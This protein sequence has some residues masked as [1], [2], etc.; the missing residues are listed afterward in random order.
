MEDSALLADLAAAFERRLAPVQ[1]CRAHLDSPCDLS[2]RG[3][4]PGGSL[5]PFFPVPS[6]SENPVALAFLT[7]TQ[8]TM[9]PTATGQPPLPR[10]AEMA[11]EGTPGATW[12]RSSPDSI[13]QQA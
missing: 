4:S 3:T 11:A 9:P 6:G 1:V 12:A 7:L 5:A 13:A 2:S 10:A 8:S